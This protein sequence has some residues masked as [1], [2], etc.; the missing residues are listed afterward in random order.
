MTPYA[1]K[2]LDES[3]D[4]SGYNIIDNLRSASTSSVSNTHAHNN[5]LVGKGRHPPGAESMR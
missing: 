4:L 2:T 3:D 1:C 5:H